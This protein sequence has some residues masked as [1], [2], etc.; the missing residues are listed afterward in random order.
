MLK[1]LLKKEITS[2]FCSVY[3]IVFALIFLLANGLM[4]WF[5]D[6]SYNILDNGYAT[7]DKFFGIS[8]FLLVILLPALTMKSF[9]E[10]RLIGTLKQQFA[11]PVSISRLYFSK[12]FAILIYML[13]IILSTF[14]YVYTVYQLALPTGNVD[15][16]VVILSYLG[17]FTIV[18]IFTFLGVFASSISKYSTLSFVIALLFNFILFY[19]FDLIAT[20]MPNIETQSFFKYL[21]IN[22][23][24]KDIQRG[25]FLSRNLYLLT[26]L[27]LAWI[28]VLLV[29]GKDRPRI[30][31]QITYIFTAFVLVNAVVFLL[32][33][34]RIDF[35]ADKR[36][37]I[38]ESSKQV[39]SQLGDKEEVKVNFY[40]ADNINYSFQR[41]KDA[42]VELI[43]DFDREISAKVT[44]ST[45]DL[46]EQ[47]I[48]SQNLPRYMASR[49]MSPITLNEKAR[50]GKIT[51]QLIYPYAEVIY[52]A[53]T[54]QV[55]LLKQLEGNTAEQN[56]NLSIENLEFE[57]IDAIN[58]LANREERHIAFVEGHN[59]IPQEYVF[60]AEEALS[61][62]F[63]VNRGEIGNEISILND[64][65]VVIIAGSTKGFNEREKYILDQYIMHGGRVLWLIDGA[66]VSPNELAE[67]GYSPAIRNGANLDDLLFTYG[68]RI[69]PDLL[70][71]TH[72]LEILLNNG[73]NSQSVAAPWTYVPLLIPSKGN[74]V[75]DNIAEVKTSFASSI[76]ILPGNADVK[77]EILLTTG[78]NTR[79]L[80]LPS[81]V[82]FDFEKVQDQKEKF[83]DSFLSVVVSL[84]GRFKSA[85]DNRLIPDSLFSTEEYKTIERSVPTKMII[86]SSSDIIKNEL[87]G[88]NQ[89]TEV[90]PL[91]YDRL[92]GRY[93][94]NKD[95][96]INAV[97]WLASD[98]SR[99]T[100]KNKKQNLALLDKQLI[101]KNRSMYALLNTFTP[102]I[103]VLIVLSALFFY[104]RYKYTK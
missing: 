12:C 5:L 52:K 54:L 73:N 28:G 34:K 18:S 59:E 17:L 35:T 42:G 91:G 30:R 41:L 1:V 96:I 11:R 103:F 69:N 101:Y 39:L 32:P 89:Q 19:G 56:L 14:I 94:G 58:L 79:K 83:N 3:S 2:L 33:N 93:F 50:G 4:L 8:S 49:G 24:F 62:Y 78:Q 84:E 102:I 80:E 26:Y 9:S 51:Q 48:S 15:L 40:L 68:V 70:Q 75:T 61:K 7:L 13:L 97:N 87:I 10:E 47:G 85:F 60:A 71:D 76:D 57:F 90:V 53:D 74:P 77:K 44:V 92:S 36:Y 95:F 65:K 81:V 72:S 38:N 31:K 64:F 45:L 66:Y 46:V 16:G 99:M 6:G 23:H 100:V 27:L 67:K 29:L 37:T 88:K 25:V 20:L 22:A 43:S 104:R 55:S 82:D 63:F 98:D 21:S 86:A